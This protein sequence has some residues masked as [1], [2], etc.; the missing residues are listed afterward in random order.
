MNFQNI[1]QVFGNMQNFQNKFNTF[2]QNFQ[3]MNQNPREL[4]QDMLNDGRMTQ[5]QFNQLSSIANMLLG[6]RF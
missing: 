1:L 6:N 3:K 5:E 2:T 4:V